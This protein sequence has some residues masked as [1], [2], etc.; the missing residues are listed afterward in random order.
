[1]GAHQGALRERPLACSLG[2]RARQVRAQ[3]PQTDAGTQLCG[4]A[5]RALCAAS[6]PA[7]TAATATAK[8]R[9]GTR[10]VIRHLAELEAI[11]LAKRGNN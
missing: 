5:L 7:S 11:Q 1:M 6:P 10:I 8:T 2:E 9:T 4:L 3:T